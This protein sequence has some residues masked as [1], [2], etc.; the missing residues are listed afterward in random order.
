M[1]AL[2]ALRPVKVLLLVILAL[3]LTI[4]LLPTTEFE[5]EWKFEGKAKIRNG[6]VQADVVNASSYSGIRLAAPL[7]TGFTP[8][9]RLGFT[10]GDQ[11][12]PAIASDRLG[13]VYVLYPQYLGVPGCPTCYSPTM[14]LLISSDHGASW[15]PPTII[16]PAGQTTGQWDAQITVDPIDGSTVYAA[17]LQNGKSDIVVGKSTDF[18]ATWSIVTADATNAGTDKPILAVRGQDVYVAYNHAQ[19]VWG[20][21]SH[22]GGA[23]FDSVKINQNGKLGWSLAGGG[24]VTPNGSVFFAWSGYEGNGGAKG[25]VNLYLSKSADG[26]ETWTTKLIEVSSSPPD[27]SAYFCGWAYLGAQMTVT[28]D[29]NGDLYALWNAGSEPRA[30]ERLY[31]SK[32]SDGGNTW[33]PRFDVST[34]PQGSHHAFPAI[35]ATGRGD[36]RIAWMDARAGTAWNVYYRSTRNGGSTWT[37]EVDVS[38][39]VP[40][41]SYITQDGFSFP[42]G[43]YFEIDIDEQ[44]TAHLVFGE[45]LN[46]DSP[47]SIWYVNGK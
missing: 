8:Q 35:V 12:E 24:T 13:H 42:F 32:S 26:G 3:V 27:C 43:D 30:P 41:Y 28:S 40:G 11:W 31:F 22:D 38:T 15:G 1:K 14:I 19:T 33:S 39:Y 20:T 6:G 5:R 7:A 4:W 21:F 34:A 17:W 45:G 44:G 46:Y 25:K 29:E 23:T 9:A 18:G 16:H 10:S 37:G 2:N 47:G 36:V